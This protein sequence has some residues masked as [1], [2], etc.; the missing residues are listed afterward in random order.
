MWI[1]LCVD[2]FFFP[3]GWG[4]ACICVSLCVNTYVSECSRE[5]VTEERGL[6]TNAAR[7]ITTQTGV[8]AVCVQLARYVA[9][10]H[11]SAVTKNTLVHTKKWKTKTIKPK[12]KDPRPRTKEP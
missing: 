6:K 10:R 7:S 12:M 5:C 9:C 3:W 1:N 4:G 8:R 2:A 11:C